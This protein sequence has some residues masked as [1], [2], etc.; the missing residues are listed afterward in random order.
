LKGIEKSLDYL[1]EIL[2]KALAED[3][4]DASEDCDV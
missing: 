2:G 3:A 1:N 4:E